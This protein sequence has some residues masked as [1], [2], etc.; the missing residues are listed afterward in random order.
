[1]K[2]TKINHLI[3]VAKYTVR[4][5]DPSWPSLQR[6]FDRDD[7]AGNETPSAF[8]ESLSFVYE[9]IHVYGCFRK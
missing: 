5:M 2:T 8:G 1:M 7:A 4:P 6:S 3:H 9:R